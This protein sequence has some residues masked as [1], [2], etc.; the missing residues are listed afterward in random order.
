MHQFL[1]LIY[2]IFLLQFEF[3]ILISPTHRKFQYAQLATTRVAPHATLGQRAVPALT[4]QVRSKRK[5]KKNLARKLILFVR[6]STHRFQRPRLLAVRPW[7][8]P[9]VFREEEEQE[10]EQEQEEQEEEKEK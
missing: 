3:V 7:N 5:G 8:L 6:S 9:G 1:N 4:R 2:L 10:Q